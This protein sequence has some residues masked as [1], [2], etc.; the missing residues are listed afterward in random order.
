[1]AKTKHL[2]P[3]RIFRDISRDFASH[4]IV[5][6]NKELHRLLAGLHQMEAMN[7]VETILEAPR[8]SDPLRV[9]KHGFKAFSQFDEEVVK[10]ASLEAIRSTPPRRS[11]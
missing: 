5:Q 10:S 4:R 3:L 1:M 11:P 7:Y 6:S 8:Y 9:Q 2:G